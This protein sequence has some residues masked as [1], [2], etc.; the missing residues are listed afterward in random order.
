VT[1][2]PGEA[3]TA[4]VVLT[5]APV[6]TADSDR[7]WAE[8]VAV[9]S[10][11][12]AAVGTEAE[13]RQLVGPSTRVVD[14]PDGLVLPGFID[15]HCHPDHGGLDRLRCDLHEAS[16]RGAYE[17]VIRS[18]AQEHP[19]AEWILGGGWSLADFPGGLPHRSIIDAIVPDRPAYLTNK[20]GHG[21]W[22]NT[23]SLEL[24]G[25]GPGTPDPGDGR[26]E[27]DPDG[28]PAG[29]LQEGAMELVSDLIP[30]PSRTD[31]EAA[32]LGGQA[33]L[34]SLGITGWQDAW[35]TRDSL[36]TYQAL[37]QRG[38]LTARV[39][40]AM[41]WDR[42]RGEEQVDE[43]LE[44]RRAVGPAG[45][46]Q[47]ASVKIMQDG[48][49]ENFTAAMLEPYLD[50]EGRPTK[51]R[52]ISFIDPEALNHYVAR[53]DAEGFQVHVH[54]IGDR[55]V[56]EAL[57]A[58]EA[59]LVAN[60]PNDHR[61]HIAH[62]QV[63]HPD[64]VARFGPLGV[65]ATTQPLWAC[66]EPQMVELCIPFLGPR[67]SGWQYPFASFLRTGTRLAL[68]SDWPVSTPEPFKILEV[69]ITRVPH[70]DHSVEPFLPEE[71]LD[72]AAAVKGF[73]MGSAFVNHL[74]GETGSISPGK[75][76]DVAVV[77]R[78]I[79][80]PANGPVGD[81]RVIATLVEGEPVYRDPSISW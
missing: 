81:A 5:G 66:A 64:D 57:D 35:V 46:L 40:A 76:A 3:G 78:D 4:D 58:F 21:A 27:R 13:I 41:W 24:A 11:R 6:Y 20:D 60:G 2:Q 31:L 45:R 34:H 39:A 72:L 28:S 9:R 75:L 43:L 19:D 74:D 71:R 63:V 10:G 61:H 38:Q 32:L 30:P 52:G 49:L 22:V 18:Y 23:R 56:R 79:F 55:A 15:A 44:L 26:I 69:A 14:L 17:A 73:T 42:G 1:S 8:A 12:F 29:V 16:G 37:S 54:A 47:A 59:A 80:D 77:D 48:I 50:E 65:A 53:L 36:A 67:R 62:V 70:D 33:Y 7:E 51:N 68:G 25:I